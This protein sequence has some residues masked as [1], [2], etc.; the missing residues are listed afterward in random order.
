L[1]SQN[2]S[3]GWIEGSMA[4]GGIWEAVDLLGVM[5]KYE[6]LSIQHFSYQDGKPN[7]SQVLIYRVSTIWQFY[8]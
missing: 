7:I 6:S 3:R 4:S 1:I 5:A 8:R 2:F